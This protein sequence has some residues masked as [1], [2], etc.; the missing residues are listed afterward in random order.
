MYG[1][2]EENISSISNIAHDSDISLPRTRKSSQ[3]PP[4]LKPLNS[5]SALLD[6]TVTTSPM[7]NG[8]HLNDILSP[9]RATPSLLKRTGSDP[10]ISVSARR[11]SKA[12]RQESRSSSNEDMFGLLR[13]LS[14]TS[15]DS[16]W[17]LGNR[18]GSNGR[19]SL[20]NPATSDLRPGYDSSFFSACVNLLNT[21]T[22]TGMIA[23]PY[24]YSKLG[25]GLATTLLV[26]FA[27]LT[28]YSLRLLVAS[29]TYL[30]K[31]SADA[32]YLSLARA[33]IPG[34]FVVLVD[35][36]MLMLCLGMA[37]SY[38]VVIGDTVPPLLGMSATAAPGWE[39]AFLVVLIPIS[40]FDSL[41][42]LTVISALALILVAYLALV[43]VGFAFTGVDAVPD[44]HV[45]WF[46][47]SP[48]F[49]VVLNIFSFAFTC[50]QNM[51]AVCS[52]CGPQTLSQ[53]DQVINIAL[54]S[55]A[56]VYLI[57]GISGYLTLGDAV[58]SNLLLIY[59]EGYLIE[60]AR[61]AYIALGLQPA[62]SS[63][64]SLVS[65][66]YSLRKPSY[67]PLSAR[68]DAGPN[69]DRIIDTTT[70]W[71]RNMC[72]T[73]AALGIVYIGALTVSRLDEV[74]ILVGTI[75]GI[76]ICYIL[77]GYFYYTLAPKDKSATYG[78]YPHFF[79]L[80]MMT[81]GGI[82]MLS[83]TLYIINELFSK[84]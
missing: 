60:G 80:A 68:E 20:T 43:V 84:I 58:T 47:A 17:S 33:T 70:N 39:L 12:N 74:L 37:C 14:I 76:P 32:S 67:A 24:A 57:V 5:S 21:I 59:P 45:G 77:P 36:A 31:S 6:S 3:K 35:V 18:V 54:G 49:F 30:H 23:M 8:V 52:E 10:H 29:S 16:L 9:I 56:I 83:T 44:P 61:I 69:P 62:R 11:W 34:R 75:G 4:G 28:W 7:D 79:A 55:T 64:D 71:K 41:E 66:F 73:L 15:D 40:L 22:G 63:L 27:C 51:F 42:V 2:L 78:G 26:S 50:H 25:I 13:S 19:S 46:V 48:E 38:L 65:S 81:L 82:I 1:A 72:L 53:I